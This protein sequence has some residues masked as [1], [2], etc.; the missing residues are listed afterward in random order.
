MIADQ[1]VIIKWPAANLEIFE[2]ML[3]DRFHYGLEDRWGN[4]PSKPHVLPQVSLFLILE[5]KPSWKVL[6]EADMI[7]GFRKINFC[8]PLITLK[9]KGVKYVR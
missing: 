4:I 1:D 5:G 7:K 2:D 3:N 8:V 6:R 9:T